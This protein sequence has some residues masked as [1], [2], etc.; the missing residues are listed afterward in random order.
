MSEIHFD[1]QKHVRSYVV[2]FA[3][4]AALTVITVG[5]SYLPIPTVP[6]ILL[7]LA[8]ASVKGALV[9]A[10]FMHLMNERQ[11]IMAILIFTAV[12]L[13]ILLVFPVLTSGS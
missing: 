11:A 10:V 8:I 9:M 2:V 13:G 5:I 1:Y 7:A 12:L 6:A 4:L 3:A